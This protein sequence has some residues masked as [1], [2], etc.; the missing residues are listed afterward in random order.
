MDWTNIE[1]ILELDGYNMGL[2][3]YTLK[4]VIISLTRKK[5]TYR[6]WLL[7]HQSNERVCSVLKK[8]SDCTYQSMILYAMW[9][10]EIGHDFV[11]LANLDYHL[12]N[13]ARLILSKLSLG[14]INLCSWLSILSSILI[15]YHIERS[16]KSQDVN[17]EI[18]SQIKKCK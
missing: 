17:R 8:N 9:I 10:H 12:S 16:C 15:S 3:L 6:Y 18:L 11:R 1:S 13:L 2:V 7:G 14:L 4:K 5:L